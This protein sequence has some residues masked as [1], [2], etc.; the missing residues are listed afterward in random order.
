MNFN[1][2]VSDDISC[3]LYISSL[4]DYITITERKISDKDYNYP[5][6]T[7]DERKFRLLCTFVEM[8]HKKV[9]NLNECI[10]ELKSKILQLESKVESLEDF[11]NRNY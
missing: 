1:T 9:K 10:Q 6:W 2:F 11:N 5:P 8:E 3:E 7:L 4:Y